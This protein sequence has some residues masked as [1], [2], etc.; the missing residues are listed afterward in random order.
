MKY[1]LGVD[2]GTGSLK[3]TVLNEKGQI[4][5]TES[6][7]YDTFSKKI[8]Y[9]E[10]NPNDW[11]IAF[12]S[13]VKKIIN[14]ID[15]FSDNLSSI[16]VAGQMHSLVLLD[17]DDKV[18]RPAILWNDVRTSDECEEIN[19][20]LDIV[21]ITGNVALEGFTLPK[22]LWLQK[23]E[24]ENWEKVSK[25]MLPKDYLVY[26]LTGEFTMDYSDASG[27]LLMD[28]TKKDWSLEI[29][30]TYNIDIN[31]VP[32]L[33]NSSEVAGKLKKSVKDNLSLSGSINVCAGAADN[34]SVALATGIND[35]ETGMLSIGTSGVLLVNNHFYMNK[36]NK[37]IHRFVHSSSD[38]EYSMGV[39]LAAGSSLTWLKNTFFE[40]ETIE[41]M[42]EYAQ[43]SNTGSNGLIFTPYLSGERTPHL[44][45][46]I[47]GTFVG[48]DQTHKKG[49][50]VNAVLEGV[51]FSLRDTYEILKTENIFLN[52]LVS[53]GGG[54]KS[55]YW[56]QIQANIFNLPIKTLK[57]EEGPAFGAAIIAAVSEGWYC[58]YD[59]AI[60]D[61]VKLSEKTVY[62]EKE[63]VIIYDEI[64]RVYK[65]IYGNTKEL[66][67]SLSKL[68]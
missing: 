49:D 9:S 1:V 15:N 21:D 56:L 61:L 37:N 38:K 65:S 55:D 66:N 50:F 20:N 4:V 46:K 5:I 60:K 29:L 24:K 25:I 35:S 68:R 45:S 6:S 16:A 3:G 13:V 2:L 59:S 18:I 63:K 12:E 11:V 54:A 44:D 53:V 28:M 30:N 19:S 23:H 22:I 48:I 40:N 39:T 26:Y 17:Q 62:P 47:R 42:I 67:N 51:V 36:R 58:D 43:A 33:L 31:K 10:Q 41:E 52:Q 14:R 32:K 27:T 57:Q 8:G 34:A 64:Y 7:S